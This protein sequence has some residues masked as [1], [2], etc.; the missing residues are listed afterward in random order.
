M[1]YLGEHAKD[2]PA[3]LRESYL[4]VGDLDAAAKSLITSLE[5]K[6][7]RAETLL[8]LQDFLP[9]KGV[10]DTGGPRSCKARDDVKAEVSRVGRIAS[11]PISQ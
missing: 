3:V 1:R 4:C 11:Y 8:E 10:T 9:P 5:A 2:A 7:T 6:E